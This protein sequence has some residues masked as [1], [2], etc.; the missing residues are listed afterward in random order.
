M[1]KTKKVEYITDDAGNK[2]VVLP[3]ETYEELLEDIQDL[4]AVAER[5]GES[6]ISF[7]DVLKNL[8]QDGLL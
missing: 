7:D 8:R 3:V 2:K 6:S 1:E 4:V 5:K